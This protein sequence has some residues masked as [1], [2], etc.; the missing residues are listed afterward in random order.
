MRHPLSY[1]QITKTLT[2]FL[3]K[4]IKL[5]KVSFDVLT[6]KR[7]PNSLMN[8]YFIISWLHS[9]DNNFTIGLKIGKEGSM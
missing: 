4:I 3:L 9:L 7:D 1:L 2:S 5:F 6:V 8:K